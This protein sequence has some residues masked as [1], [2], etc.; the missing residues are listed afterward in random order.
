MKNILIFFTIVLVLNLVVPIV[1]RVDTKSLSETFDNKISSISNNT[2]LTEFWGCPDLRFTNG[3]GFFDTYKDENNV[4]WF[5]TPNG[6][7]FYSVGKE[8]VAAHY[9]RRYSNN[10][11]EIYDSYENWSKKV[12]E[13][14][15]NWGLN[16][17]GAWCNYSL[18]NNVTFENNETR[19]PYTHAFTFKNEGRGIWKAH[20]K[21]HF[22]DVFDGCFWRLVNYSIKKVAEK[23]RDDPYLIGYWLDNE[24]HWEPC[25]FNS[26]D[27]NKKTL[28]EDYLSISYERFQPG[29]MKAV[30]FLIKRYENVGIGKFNEVW[31]MELHDFEELY[32]AEELGRAGWIIQHNKSSRARKDI[33]EF[34]ELVAEAYFEN[35]TSI[36]RFYDPNHLILGVRFHAWGAPE[37]VVNI[38]GKYCDVVS[39]NYYRKNLLFYNPVRYFQ[40]V[41]VRLLPLDNWL[42]GY[43]AVAKKPLLVGEWGTDLTGPFEWFS[44]PLPEAFKAI[45]YYLFALKCLEMPYVIGFQGWYRAGTESRSGIQLLNVEDEKYELI[46]CAAKQINSQIYKI[47]SNGV[48]IG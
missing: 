29:K 45:Y 22:P 15:K 30:D 46:V 35:I 23:L 1:I 21:K 33:I 10:V 2:N 40:S 14:Y 25:P 13:N 5:V 9:S 19:I 11:L 6:Y 28:L 26:D 31:G 16:T 44:M 20:I 34:N 27:F 32:D 24:M 17:L 47:H 48:I 41:S 39:V 7:A 36:L 3:N 43:Y 8:S 42:E 37:E 4:W 18:I 12:F 38:T